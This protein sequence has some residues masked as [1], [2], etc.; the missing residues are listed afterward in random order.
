MGALD[1][2]FSGAAQEAQRAGFRAMEQV[3]AAPGEVYEAASIFRQSI[4]NTT[5]ENHLR[6]PLDDDRV[7]KVA[8]ASGLP[9]VRVAE[10]IGTHSTTRQSLFSMIDAGDISRGQ[11]GNIVGRSKF[12]QGHI[13]SNPDQVKAALA[14]SDMI[15]SG[16]IDGDAAIKKK[17][18][19]LARQTAKETRSVRARSQGVSGTLADMAGSIVGSLKDPALLATLPIGAGVITG[20][21]ILANFGKAFALEGA[22]A[23]VSEGYT[24]SQA[25]LRNREL[26]VEYTAREAAVET[27]SAVLGAGAIRG[28]GSVTVDVAERV[29]SKYRALPMEARTPQAEDA[30]QMLEDFMHTSKGIPEDKLPEHVSNLKQAAHDLGENRPPP[31]PDGLAGLPDGFKSGQSETIR[32]F[33]SKEKSPDMG[34]RFGQDV[35]PAGRYMNEFH[36]GGAEPLLR[37][38]PKK[39][40]SGEVQFNRPLMIDTDKN[41]LVD[42]KRTLSSAYD[43]KT[44]KALSKALAADGYDGII[45]FDKHGRGEIVDLTKFAKPPLPKDTTTTIPR[46]KGSVQEADAATSKPRANQP[47]PEPDALAETRLA[48]NSITDQDQLIMD[49]DAAEKLVLDNPD[50]KVAQDV[51]LDRGQRALRTVSAKEAL[52]EQ[53]NAING[54]DAVAK[55]VNS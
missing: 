13:N 53:D 44:G 1:T 43:G 51:V 19:E 35:E 4:V 17:V 31:I 54:L 36:A 29:L 12:A 22:L 48:A 21:S 37:D 26:G 7:K 28:I 33:R 27:V 15:R 42:W 55:C 3:A 47:E 49:M 16:Q 8:E 9:E 45:T 23:G 50:M 25:F 18:A 39:Y 24:Q 46:R 5:A 30:A 32:F 34:D 14:A 41:G 40:E 52:Q 10:A 6:A 2:F 11:D 38:F 20:P